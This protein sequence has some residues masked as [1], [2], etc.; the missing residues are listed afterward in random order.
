MLAKNI[1]VPRG[2][3]NGARGVVKKFDTSGKGRGKN[4]LSDVLCFTSFVKIVQIF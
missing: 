2:L 3:V 4:P 1:D